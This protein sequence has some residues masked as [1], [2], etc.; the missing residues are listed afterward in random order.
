MLS[1]IRAPAALTVALGVYAA[2]PDSSPPPAV[3][4]SPAAQDPSA[5]WIAIADRDDNAT[6][7]PIARYQDGSWDN[8]PWAS[9][10]ALEGIEAVRT[11]DGVWSW[12]DARQ[13]W[14][15][16]GRAAD[17]LGWT[18]DMIATGVP[19]SWFLYS[20][21]E[22]GLPLST[23]E[24]VLAQAHCLNRWAIRTDRDVQPAS[25]TGRGTDRPGIAF[26][27]TPA[28][29]H[30]EDDIPGLDRIRSTLGFA[31]VSEGNKLD[32]SFYWLGLFRFDG[33][34]EDADA[35]PGPTDGAT[36]LT[37]ATT[38]SM[39]LGVLWGRYYE[40]AEYILIRID[41]DRSSV[42]IRTSEGGC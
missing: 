7:V 15:H 35:A 27:R 14:G 39:T 13:Y 28:A 8:A 4:D 3:A 26:T 31:D 32:R 21:S 22:E 6:L 38:E 42:I 2:A 9:L 20:R 30:T 16:P 10:I 12:P 36:G 18:P 5:L 11:G 24:L 41:G 17:T 37:S 25:E 19:T 33:G 1:R 29:V 40:G 34:R 23:A